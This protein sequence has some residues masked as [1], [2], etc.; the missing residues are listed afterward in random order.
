MSK[1]NTKTQNMISTISG[2]SILIRIEFN[3]IQSKT[4]IWSI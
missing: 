1:V 3:W 4:V 2:E